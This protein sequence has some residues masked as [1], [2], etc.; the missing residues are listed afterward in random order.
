LG[1]PSAVDKPPVHT[2]RAVP[3]FDLEYLHS[4]AELETPSTR[5]AI[6]RNAMPR[7][8]VVVGAL[9]ALASLLIPG[10]SA[11]NCTALTARF[12]PKLGNG[13][14]S[15]VIAT[16]LRSPRHIVI[17]AAGNLLVAEGGS[18]S[19]R[20]LVLKENDD[21]TVCV[22]SNEVL[23]SGT[24]HEVALSADGKTLF[25]SNLASVTAYPYDAEKG[26]VGTGKVIINNMSNQGTHPT[27]AIMVSKINPDI[28]LVARGSNSNIDTATAQLSTGRA[29]IKM[30]SISQAAAAPVDFNA[31]GETLGWGLRNIVGMG[32]DPVYGGVVSFFSPN[33]HVPTPFS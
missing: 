30:F 6:S 21:G 9:A 24:N 32:E 23:A 29:V 7:M 19:V 1:T 27:R 13:Y 4:F 2:H 8:Q 16:G 3:G 17:D 12:A 18:S 22:T 31:G 5:S 10:V 25:V 14:T 26:T 33:A 15:A 20:R 28:I 11:Q